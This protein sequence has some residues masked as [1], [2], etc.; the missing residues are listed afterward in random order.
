MFVFKLFVI[1]NK[2][3]QKDKALWYNFCTY[4]PH[5]SARVLYGG[6]VFNKVNLLYLKSLQIHLLYQLNLIGHL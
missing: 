1:L 6:R 4:S 5:I 2:Y 3:N